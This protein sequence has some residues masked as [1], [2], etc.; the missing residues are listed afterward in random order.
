[1]AG[2][3]AVGH[4]PARSDVAVLVGRDEG[5]AEVRVETE[6][7][8]RRSDRRG[9]PR[10]P[11]ARP[12]P[13]ARRTSPRGRRGPATGRRQWSAIGAFGR[14]RA[15][16]GL[17]GPG[18]E[19][20]QDAADRRSSTPGCRQRIGPDDRRQRPQQIH[21]RACWN[22]LPLPR[23]GGEALMIA[24][25]GESGEIGEGCPR[26]EL[27]CHGARPP[28]PSLERRI[29]QACSH[30]LTSLPSCSW[31][32]MARR[33][34]AMGLDPQGEDATIAGGRLRPR[35]MKTELP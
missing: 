8:V 32:P 23:E 18:L 30:F 1:M 24:V 5:V 13:P 34:L 4:P 19:R 16:L 15:W 31:T 26:S 14:C 12:P 2:E 33:S 6:I 28:G 27:R 29:P 11:S 3:F 21:G 17:G 22:A 25:V 35:P 7:E 20:R 9:S 10:T